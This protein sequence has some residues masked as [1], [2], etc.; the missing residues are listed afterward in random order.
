MGRGIKLQSP[1]GLPN[2]SVS[3]AGSLQQESRAA[4]T[5]PGSSGTRWDSPPAFCAHLSGDVHLRAGQPWLLA[6]TRSSC[7]CGTATRGRRRR[8]QRVTGSTRGNRLLLPFVPGASGDH[9]RPVCRQ[10]LRAAS[11]LLFQVGS[12]ECGVAHNTPGK[13]GAGEGGGLEHLGAVASRAALGST[14]RLFLESWGASQDTRNRHQRLT[15]HPTAGRAWA[16]ARSWVCLAG[17][18]ELRKKVQTCWGAEPGAVGDC[19]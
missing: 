9:R 14:A 16:A 3:L 5:Y 8:P 2:P 10:A 11:L 12:L 19:W 15:S 18:R 7:C 6:R 1:C 13:A 17:K 4:G